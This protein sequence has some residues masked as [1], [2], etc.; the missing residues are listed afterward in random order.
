MSLS[1]WQVMYYVPLLVVLIVMLSVNDPW[2]S[3]LARQYHESLRFSEALLVGDSKFSVVWGYGVLPY[4]VSSFIGSFGFEYFKWSFYVFLVLNAYLVSKV[5][6]RCGG[7]DKL[8][9]LLWPVS[10]GGLLV[11][12]DITFTISLSLFLLF[13]LLASIDLMKYALLLSV[14]LFLQGFTHQVLFIASVVVV[15]GALVVNAYCP[16]TRE[17]LVN[18]KKTEVILYSLLLLWAIGFSIFEVYLSLSG[19]GKVASAIEPVH[20]VATFLNVIYMMPEFDNYRL[21]IPFLLLLAPFMFGFRLSPYKLLW[22]SIL[23]ITLVTVCL[24]FM[25]MDLRSLTLLWCAILFFYGLAFNFK[26]EAKRSYWW[27][28][29][30]LS[31]VVAFFATMFVWKSIDFSDA[32][33][34]LRADLPPSGDKLVFLESKAKFFNGLFDE[35]YSLGYYLVDDK[36]NMVPQ[37]YLSDGIPMSY[38]GVHYLVLSV[39][40]D[41]SIDK[42]YD[43]RYTLTGSRVEPLK[44]H[45]GH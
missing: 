43:L 28:N 4:V 26:L 40:D 10:V 37:N 13:A 38:E 3:E 16:A 21:A 45:V 30:V 24:K 7:S 42:G 27:G 19:S 39:P 32:T 12:G 11:T 34:S 9:F 8:W 29:F 6:I 5:F 2:F 44:V 36:T 18:L 35:H 33:N 1:R 14:I 22:I 31:V 25:H 17:R 41:V 20:L 23:S 15:I